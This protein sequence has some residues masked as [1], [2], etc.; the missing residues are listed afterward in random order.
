MFTHTFSL[1]CLFLFCLLCTSDSRYINGTLSPTNRMSFNSVITRQEWVEMHQPAFEAC[2]KAGVVSVMCSYNEING[3]PSCASHE[4]LTTLLRETWNFTQPHNF[5]VRAHP[6]HSSTT[7]IDSPLAHPQ[8]PTQHSHHRTH[9]STHSHTTRDSHQHSCVG[10][11][12]PHA[13]GHTH[14]LSSGQYYVC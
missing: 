13:R 5:V 10:C 6:S 4:L 14:S 9:P 11:A 12:R 1:F 8:N 2:V 3:V 7:S